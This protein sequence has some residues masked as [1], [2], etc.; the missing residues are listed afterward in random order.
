L[1]PK[2]HQD[3]LVCPV[4]CF[5]PFPNKNLPAE[6]YK[7]YIKPDTFAVHL[8]HKSWKKTNALHYIRQGKVLRSFYCLSKELMKREKH[9]DKKY[10]RKIGSALKQQLFN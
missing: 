6:K 2:E 9:I 7:D 5:Y 1:A 8:W 10:L 4:D 3:L